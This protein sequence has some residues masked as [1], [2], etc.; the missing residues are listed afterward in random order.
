MTLSNSLSNTNHKS[1]EQIHLYQSVNGIRWKKINVILRAFLISNM[2]IFYSTLNCTN[3]QT[4][5]YYLRVNYYYLH[6]VSWNYR[7]M[8]CLWIYIMSNIIWLVICKHTCYKFTST[9]MI[10]H[11][12]EQLFMYLGKNLLWYGILLIRFNL[13]LFKIVF[14]NDYL[15]INRVLVLNL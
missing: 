9:L 10:T 13:L 11:K 14:Y 7:L 2:V 3:I 8:A 5:I 12:Q 6:N 15:S 1:V 4:T